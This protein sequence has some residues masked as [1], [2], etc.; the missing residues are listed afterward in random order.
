MPRMRTYRCSACEGQFD[1]MHH[2]ADEPPP[3]FCPLCG[4]DTEGEAPTPVLATPHLAGVAGKA[5]DAVWKAEQQGADFR[6]DYAQHTMGLDKEAADQLRITDM[7]DNLRAGDTSNIPIVNP[8]ST[9]MAANPGLGGFANT[10]YSGH[11]SA[12]QSG[13][14]PN[15]GAQAMAFV[16]GQ[17]ASFT[18]GAGHAGPV[19]SER[20]ALETQ[21]PGYRPRVRS[22]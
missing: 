7:K 18:A 2:P 8:V 3:R 12:V 5:G 16:R 9:F 4:F 14:F 20:P 13:P 19:M 10:D 15:A 22:R 21:Q 6:A 11:S 1:F 17:H